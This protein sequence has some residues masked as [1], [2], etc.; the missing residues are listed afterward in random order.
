MYFVFEIPLLNLDK[1]GSNVPREGT[2]NRDAGH[3]VSGVTE[4]LEIRLGLAF[5]L[6]ACW[7]TGLHVDADDVS[8]VVIHGSPKAT[9]AVF[10]KGLLD[11]VEEAGR[12]RFPSFVLFGHNASC[13]VHPKNPV[14]KGLVP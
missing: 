4:P 6:K 5:P 12:G 3:V 9:V 1:S 11:V 10:D 2:V 13:V 8:R 14:G 7:V